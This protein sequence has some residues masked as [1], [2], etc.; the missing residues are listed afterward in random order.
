MGCLL[1]DSVNNSVANLIHRLH[2]SIDLFTKIQLTYCPHID[3]KTS[4]EKS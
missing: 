4:R 2:Y 1:H 3:L